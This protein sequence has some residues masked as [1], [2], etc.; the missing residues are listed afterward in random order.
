MSL[1]KNNVDILMISETKLDESFPDGQ[2][3][4]KGYSKPFRLDRNK[5]VGAL[6]FMLGKISQQ[7]LYQLRNLPLK[8]FLLRLIYVIENGFFD[9]HTIQIKLQL[10]DI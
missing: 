5:M 3:T 8:Q 10:K 6:C 4:V 7:G 9:A 1:I 2:F